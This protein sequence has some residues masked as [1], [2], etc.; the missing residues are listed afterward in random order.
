MKLVRHA[1]LCM[2]DRVR[3][4]HGLH[5]L[6]DNRRLR[7]AARRHSRDMVAR[8]YFDHVTP[9]G[10]TMVTRILR[11]HYT[12]ASA[13]WTL[14]ENLAWGTQRLATPAEIVRAWMHSPAHRENILFRGFREIGIGIARSVPSHRGPV[15]T[16]AAD[17]GAT[18]TT[19]FGARG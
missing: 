12:R 19:D 11:T 14:G 18:Y 13:P 16:S 1:T 8:H 3:V 2:I 10:V 9:T 17:A 15:A 7:V 6:R 4:M 5:R